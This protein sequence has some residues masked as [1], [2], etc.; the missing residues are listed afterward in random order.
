MIVLDVNHEIFEKI[1]CFGIRFNYYTTKLIPFDPPFKEDLY[2]LL[3]QI[4]LFQFVKI[5]YQHKIE[6]YRLNFLLK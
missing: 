2:H 1:N 4:L 6:K 5:E 3:G